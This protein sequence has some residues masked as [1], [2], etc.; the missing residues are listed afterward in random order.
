MRYIIE[1]NTYPIRHDLALIGCKRENGKWISSSADALER[2]SK[3]GV[4]VK[5]LKIAIDEPKPKQ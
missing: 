2:L 4:K 1:G 5:N 3:I